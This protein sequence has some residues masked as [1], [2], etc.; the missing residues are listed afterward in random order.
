M[1]PFY[2]LIFAKNYNEALSSL[3]TLKPDVVLLDINLPGMDGFQ[4]LSLL[5]EQIQIFNTSVLMVSSNSDSFSIEKA[6]IHGASDYIKKPY[7]RIELLLRI[8]SHIRSKEIKSENIQNKLEIEK[9]KKKSRETINYTKDSMVF[10][11]SELAK[12]RDNET[13]EH[14]NRIKSYTK[15]LIEKLALTSKYEKYFSNDD[16][17]DIFCMSILHDIGKIGIS[18]NI[19][20]KP[21][22]LTF[23]EF[24]VMKTHSVIGGEI[25]ENAYK[26]YTN[27]N[28]LKVGK[29]IAL[30]H[31]EKWNGTGYPLGLK[32]EEIPVAARIVAIVDVFDALVSK[33]IYKVA[34]SKADTF[35]IIKEERGRHFDPYIF[36]VFFEYKDK[37]IEIGKRVSYE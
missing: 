6:F 18:D 14:L 23:D 32:G 37:F 16:I 4:V 9:I 13:G 31:H 33:R 1:S 35:T 5:Y 15:Y 2:E 29:D 17:D 27:F 30:Y 10:T 24:E 36:D 25:L 19:L 21:G 34:Y 12:I 28:F 20:K 3:T 8:G 7:N 22:K 26:H 11:L